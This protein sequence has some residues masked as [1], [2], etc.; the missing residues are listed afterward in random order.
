MPVKNLLPKQL[1][2]SRN[3]AIASGI[4]VLSLLFCS[5]ALTAGTP[6]FNSLPPETAS[7]EQYQ[8]HNRPVIVFAPSEKDADYIRQMAILEK[9]KADLADRD[10]IVL[11]D[12]RPAAGGQL[13]SQFKPDGFEVVLVGKDGGVKVRQTTPLSSEELLST[14]DRMPMRKADLR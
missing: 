13:R 7:L 8:W 3:S 10:I 4:L 2:P 11:S 5:S 9:S 12:T 14:I 1:Y 6:M